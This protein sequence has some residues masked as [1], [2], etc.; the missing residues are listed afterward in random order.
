MIE[1]TPW[2]IDILR[3]TH[4][5]A[6]RFNPEATVRAY[7]ESQAVEFALTDRA[8]EGDLR[9]ERDGFVLLLERG[10]EGTVDVEEPHDRLVLRPPGQAASS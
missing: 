9:I 1:F 2:A 8:E 10:L 5:A 7:R 3:K 6:R 4:E